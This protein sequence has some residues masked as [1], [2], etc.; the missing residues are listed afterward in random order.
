LWRDRT[1]SL[2][3]IIPAWLL[4][5]VLLLAPLGLMLKDSFRPLGEEDE[6][7]DLVV[8]GE[9][10]THYQAAFR[11]SA[12]T[13]YWRSFW[14][15]TLTTAITL[16]IGYPVAYYVAMIAPRRWRSLLLIAVAV[17]FWTSL[18]IRTS[19]WKLILG[20]GGPIDLLN[21]W[22]GG[23]GFDWNNTPTAVILSLV[24]CE[25]PFMILPLYASMEK[26][27]RTL[28]Q[29][30]NDLGAAPRHALW[31]VT[32]PLTRPGILAG[33]AIV[34][35]G[36]AGQ[37]VIAEL[38][39]GGKFPLAGWLINS[40]F[41]GDSPS[42]NRG[43]AISFVVMGLVLASMVG[44]FAGVAAVA[45]CVARMIRMI[46][47]GRE[48]KVIPVND[49]GTRRG[50]HAL[51]ARIHRI[52]QHRTLSSVTGLTLFF[53]YLPILM[54][55]LFSFNASSGQAVW[56]G[57][58]LKWYSAALANEEVRTAIGHTL[59]VAAGST[60]IAT[61]V[62]TLAGLALA[63]KFPGW[64]VTGALLYV[65]VVIP[66]IVLAV[67]LLTILI[68]L[69]WI[70]TQGGL[71]IAHAA[72]C[73][74]YVAIVV[75]ARLAGFDR[76]LEEAARDLGA[77]RLGVFW[78][79][80]FPLMLPGIVSGAILA[81][82]VSVDDYLVTSYVRPAGYETLPTYIYGKVHSGVTPEV[83]AISTLM[84]LATAVIIAAGYWLMRERR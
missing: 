25:L 27:D 4:L 24:Y 6:V 57:F 16:A 28:V 77:G 55:I 7:A 21:K 53:L 20:T 5:G 64:R 83:N 36:S 48:S 15:A 76:T 65:P 14:V 31:R 79:V 70:N 84:L 35:I 46:A 29:A 67:A 17:P 23:E 37:Y 73:T 47:E 75:R 2:L 8:V 52:L 43:A 30:A 50:L 68:A 26:L 40:Y 51:L 49:T 41:L 82:T 38:M 81:M 72:F 19:A 13:I 69:R 78:R 80:K 22:M 74:S 66:E 34:Y 71:I 58:T 11:P 12:R 42:P 54:L 59:S 62:G 18:V 39:A 45:W 10:Q 56:K 61:I 60:L 63:K 44:L 32:I 33:C 1:T 3:Q 9:S